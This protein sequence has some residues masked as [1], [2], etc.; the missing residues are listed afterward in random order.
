MSRPRR[1][2]AVDGGRHGGHHRRILLVVAALLTALVSVPM[3]AAGAAPGLPGAAPPVAVPGADDPPVVT[4]D[5][6]RDRYVGT[7]AV[8]LPPSFGPGERMGAAGCADCQWRL[9]TSCLR[10]DEAS[11][12]GTTGLCPPG[13][14]WLRFWMRRPG[15]AWQ[16]L[17]S[18]CVGPGGPVTMDRM[19]DLVADRFVR[20]LPDPD[21]AAQPRRGAVT[22][23]PLVF[24][25]G[26]PARWP[27]RTYDLLGFAVTVRAVP[28]WSWD[29]D[30]GAVFRT[31]DPGGRW[32]QDA[33]SHTY[34]S[35]GPRTV[36]LTTTW[37]AT[38]R[39]DGLGPFPVPET[40]RQDARLAV[41][42]GEARAVL[43]R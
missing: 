9:T 10:D 7:G 28:R 34:R 38:F 14:E 30:D 26:Q 42:V 4:G 39:V 12:G 13:E 22:R 23:L 8:L 29:F 40:V 27:A 5:D 19:G 6:E 41:R 16:R 25:S 17:G 32:P 3:P 35:A 36:A 20:D 33:V 24:R 1:R 31:S 15:E 18:G 37:T 11:C 21:P 2:A 43:V